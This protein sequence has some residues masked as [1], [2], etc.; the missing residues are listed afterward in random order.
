MSRTKIPSMITDS[1]QASL[2]KMPGCGLQEGVLKII[3]LGI[4]FSG[5]A[6]GVILQSLHF[7]RRPLNKS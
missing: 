2:A 5:K 6:G 7:P 1:N 3:G 4:S